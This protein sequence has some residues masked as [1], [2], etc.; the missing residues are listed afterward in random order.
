MVMP[1]VVTKKSKF[2]AEAS[3]KPVKIQGNRKTPPWEGPE[4]DGVTF[5]LLSRFLVCRERF[6]ILVVEGLKPKPKFDPKKD[7]GN[8]WHICEE[9]LAAGRNFST[10]L[11]DLIE[12]YMR[13]FPFQRDEVHHWY[14]KCAVLFPVAVEYWKSHREVKARTPLLQEQVFDVPHQLPSGRVVRLRGKWDAVDLVGGKKDG[15]IY[16][17]ENK[18]KSQIDQAKIRRQLG[19][20]LQTMIYCIALESTEMWTDSQLGISSW[21]WAKPLGGVRY[22]VVRRSAHKSASSMMEKVNLDLRED[23]GSEWFARWT[24]EVTPA[25]MERFLRQCLDPILEQLCHWWDTSVIG[26]TVHLPQWATSFRFPFGI[27]NPLT[28]GG[29]AE[30]DGYLDTGSA[31]GLQRV[32]TLFP[33]L[34]GGE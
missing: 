25:D 26:K 34:E 1:K 13:Q 27:Y 7:F 30:V 10:D 33:E 17:Q 28:E 9:A 3:R 21:V 29:F 24:V 23:R 20:D 4:V 16:I 5:S 32:D 15:V 18:T 8:M 12:K 19:F 31:L 11:S 22:N 14:E 6:R 2:V